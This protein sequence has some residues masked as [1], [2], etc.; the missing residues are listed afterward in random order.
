[1][2]PHGTGEPPSPHR[3]LHDLVVFSPVSQTNAPSVAR[4]SDYD[5]VTIAVPRRVEAGADVEVHFLLLNS[6]D[7]PWTAGAQLVA[8]DPL[9]LGSDSVAVP[10]VGPGKVAHIKAVARTTQFG[11]LEQEWA[12]LTDAGVLNGPALRIEVV[13]S[14]PIV[15]AQDLS[16]DAQESP[17]DACKLESVSVA[18]AT[19]NQAEDGD[20][21]RWLQ[22]IKERRL[23]RIEERRLE[24]IQQRAEL[25]EQNAIDHFQDIPD[26]ASRDE[27]GS[28]DDGFWAV[29]AT[30]E[31]RAEDWDAQSAVLVEENAVD[32]VEDTPDDTSRDGGEATQD[33][34]ED[35]GVLVDEGAVAMASFSEPRPLIN[36]EWS[37]EANPL[38]DW[39]VLEGDV[40]S[41]PDT[42]ESIEVD[43]PEPAGPP[44]ILETCT[45]LGGFDGLEGPRDV[46][47]D[48]RDLFILYWDG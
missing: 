38:T 34:V 19:E 42:V 37:G 31:D 2:S 21:E 26:D 24:R 43:P 16:A 23:Q 3:F 10:P 27:N 17:N 7:R 32:E 36:L 33:Q 8:T 48:H 4:A 22:R 29:E 41:I 28:L 40:A 1:M 9:V 39:T 18:E 45:L 44:L 14:A 47:D 35:E 13:S 15:A 6:S 20:A 25:M 30:K 12:I 46:T 11:L 5:V